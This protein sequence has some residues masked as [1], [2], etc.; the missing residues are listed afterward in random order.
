M[1]SAC[2]GGIPAVPPGQQA[3][4]VTGFAVVG[5]TLT[6]D[7]A[8]QTLQLTARLLYGDGTFDDESSKAAWVSSNTAVATVSSNGFVAAVDD[9]STTVTATYEGRSASQ[10]VTVHID[11]QF[12]WTFLGS[13]FTTGVNDVGV[14]DI[15]VDPRDDQLLYVASD[16]GVFV[17]RNQGATWTQG[18][19]TPRTGNHPGVL[20]QDA[21]NPDRVFYGGD[22]VL[23]ISTDKGLTWSA[24]KDFPP[25]AIASITASRFDRRAFFVGVSGPSNPGVFRSVDDGATWESHA[26]PYPVSGATAFIPWSI[27]EDPGDGTLYVTTELS[28]HPQPYHP[29]AFRSVDRGLSWQDVTGALPWHGQKIIVQPKTGQVYFLTEGSGLFTSTDHGL[30]WTRLGNAIFANTLTI[31][32]NNLAQFFGGELVDSKTSRGG[33]AFLSTDGAVTFN[34]YGLEGRIVSSL[35]VSGDSARLFAACYNSGIFV[36]RLR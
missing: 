23:R 26:F 21:T 33:G 7:A 15:I 1:V 36:R 11:Q 35:S 30:S 18:F 34:P 8:G 5:T 9:G 10:I 25:N 27:G 4:T 28:D 16:R 29:P 17:S 19:A 20:A 32:P 24:L 12:N 14:Y 6:L 2:A 31:D 22:G 13:I 3:K